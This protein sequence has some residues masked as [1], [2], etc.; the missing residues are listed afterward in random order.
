MKYSHIHIHYHIPIKLTILEIRP[1]HLGKK[2][3]KS[4]LNLFIHTFCIR[5]DPK[6][7]CF[8]FHVCIESM[9]VFDNELY[10]LGRK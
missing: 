4:M 2:M 5:I 1:I 10:A 3:L 8:L 7:L 6:S 9:L